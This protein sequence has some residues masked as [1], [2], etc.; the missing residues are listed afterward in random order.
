MR[1][2]K[3]I[4]M[5]EWKPAEPPPEGFE[6]RALTYEPIL[7]YVALGRFL[8]YVSTFAVMFYLAKTFVASF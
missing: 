2:E 7:N 6:E 4:E 3:E 5:N 1:R 8:I